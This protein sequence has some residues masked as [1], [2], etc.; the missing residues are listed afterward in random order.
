MYWVRRDGSEIRAGLN[1][2][3]AEALSAGF[4]DLMARFGRA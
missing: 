2:A 4:V 3:T 1:F